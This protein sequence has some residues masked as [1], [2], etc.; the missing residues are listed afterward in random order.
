MYRHD[1]TVELSK[2]TDGF[3]RINTSNPDAVADVHAYIATVQQHREEK[4][5]AEMLI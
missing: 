2:L 1:Q 5:L 3:P 4:Y